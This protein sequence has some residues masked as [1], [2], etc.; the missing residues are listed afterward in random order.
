[1]KICVA[2]VLF[3]IP[4]R[5]YNIPRNSIMSQFNDL[6]DEDKKKVVSDKV[7]VVRREPVGTEHLHEDPKSPEHKTSNIGEQTSI[8]CLLRTFTYFQEGL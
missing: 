5:R 6:T 3:N 1:M 2:G 4:L 7:F 8:I